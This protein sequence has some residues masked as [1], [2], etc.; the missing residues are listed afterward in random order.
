MIVTDAVFSMDGGIAPLPE[1][2]ELGG[3]LRRVRHARRRA[4][5]GRAR[6]ERAKGRSSTS[7]SRG[8]CPS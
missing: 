2:V 8:A 3:S 5:D 6:A 1:I 4:R 7:A